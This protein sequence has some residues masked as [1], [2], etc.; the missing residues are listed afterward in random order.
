L[1]FSFVPVSEGPSEDKADDELVG[2]LVL[3]FRNLRNLP[4]FW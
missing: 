1:C 3:L 4:L 2:V